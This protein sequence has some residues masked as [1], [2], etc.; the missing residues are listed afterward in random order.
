MKTTY[1][2]W[3]SGFA[4]RRNSSYFAKQTLADV[5]NVAVGAGSQLRVLLTKTDAAMVTGSFPQRSCL[6]GKTRNLQMVVIT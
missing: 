4:S 6:V 2:S 1:L 5:R 3:Y